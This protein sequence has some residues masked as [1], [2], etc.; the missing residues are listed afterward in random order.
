[1][2]ALHDLRSLARRDADG[3]RRLS[4]EIDDD[5][6]ILVPQLGRDISDVAGLAAV[7]RPFLF[8]TGRERSALLAEHAF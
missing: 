3:L 5:R 6:P 2:Q 8:A 7:C 4:D 1:M